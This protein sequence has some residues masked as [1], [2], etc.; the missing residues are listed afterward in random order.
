MWIFLLAAMVGNAKP[1]ANPQVTIDTSKGPIVVELYADKAPI[2]VKNFLQY[3][4]EKFYDGTIFHRVIPNF[5]V[6]GGGFTASM[7]QKQTH[8]P[9]KN[10]GG[11]GLQNTRGTLAMARTAVPDSASSQFF[12][13]LKDNGFLDRAA[14]PDG[15][16]Y[17]VF[18]KVISGM[19]V[20]DQIAA[21]RTTTKGMYQDVPA[22]AV[23]IK[24]VRV[25][26]K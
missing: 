5:M 19:E 2:S 4:H 24:S 14:S 20:V 13:N 7:D 11:N 12:I 15:V 17:A 26:K 21:V 9:I 8:A 10:E 3:A 6:Q 16:G 18:G 23:T 25:T 22:E 1:A